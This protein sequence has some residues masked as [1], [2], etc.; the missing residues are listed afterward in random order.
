MHPNTIHSLYRRLTHEAID[1][2]GEEF[3]RV[4]LRIRPFPWW[5]E[6]TGALVDFPDYI[7]PSEVALNSTWLPALENTDIEGMLRHELA[8]VKSGFDAGHNNTWRARCLEFGVK[9]EQFNAPER[10]REIKWVRPD[11]AEECIKACNAKP[12][13]LL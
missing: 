4:P 2:W 10:W 7:N 11:Y 9:P 8:H 5:D 6:L 12:M 3:P 1:L 13:Q